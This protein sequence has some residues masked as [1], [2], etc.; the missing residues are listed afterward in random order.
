[1]MFAV[2][3]S[4]LAYTS[5]G[6]DE[7]PTKENHSLAGY[8]HELANDTL[9]MLEKLP[10]SDLTVRTAKY[11]GMQRNAVKTTRA[12]AAKKSRAAQTGPAGTNSA[13]SLHHS[14]AIYQGYSELLTDIDADGYY[15][16]FSVSFDAD[17]LSPIIGEQARV[18][19]DLYLS[20]NGGPWLLYFSTD[21]FIITGE[22]T[23]D[24]FEV[25]T[26]LDSGYAPD[27]YDVLIDLYEVGYSDVVASYSSN[28]TNALY[29]LPLESAD[30][31]PEYVEVIHYD[32]H[33]GSVAWGIVLLLFV[34]IGR[35]RSYTA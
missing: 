4:S 20:K 32:E 35:Q 2:S 31:D 16:T 30:Y 13:V 23:D 19:A 26:R 28:D 22:R 24:E 34:F 11:Q 27:H 12:T 29:A 17:V 9:T 18:Y 21:D 1:M 5:N 25:I 3:Y 14:F 6:I 15:Q 8:K 10:D 7:L 33:G